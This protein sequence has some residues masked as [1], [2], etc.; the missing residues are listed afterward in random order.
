[1]RESV[2]STSLIVTQLIMTAMTLNKSSVS[3]V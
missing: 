3:R 2:L 1:M